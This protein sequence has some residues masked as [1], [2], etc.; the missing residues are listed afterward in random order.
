MGGGNPTIEQFNAL[1]DGFAYQLNNAQLDTAVDVAR[2]SVRSQVEGRIGPNNYIRKRMGDIL[3]DQVT[4][5]PA[6]EG[7]RIQ[8][9]GGGTAT[10][11]NGKWTNDQTGQEVK[12]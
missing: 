2:K 6:P 11:K 7:H 3:E 4:P 1:R 5:Q 12:F 8:L 10:K 9:P